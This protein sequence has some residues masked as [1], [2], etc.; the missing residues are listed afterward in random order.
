LS[1]GV[2]KETDEIVFKA[3]ENFM[4]SKDGV[5]YTSDGY[6]TGTIN[7]TG[8]TIGSFTLENGSFVGTDTNQNKYIFGN[9]SENSILQAKRSNGEILLDI[10]GDGKIKLGNFII[11]GDSIATL[12]QN[13]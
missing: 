3:G 5:L 10:S 2:T 9:T 7:A 13:D 4:V 12:A 6:F 11:S 8:G 1:G